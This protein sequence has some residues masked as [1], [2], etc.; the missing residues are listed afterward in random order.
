M[1]LSW[2]VSSGESEPPPRLYRYSVRCDRARAY[3]IAAAAK[4]AGMSEEAFVQAHF[5]R[6]L[7]PVEEP[8]PADPAPEGAEKKARTAGSPR[9]GDSARASDLGVHAPALRCWPT[10]TGH[11][12]STQG[13]MASSPPCRPE[14]WRAPLARWPSAGWSKG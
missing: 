3:D 14:R 4:R 5:D 10:R 1:S 2:V 6:I 7:D 9:A 8:A 11:S 13:P 12:L